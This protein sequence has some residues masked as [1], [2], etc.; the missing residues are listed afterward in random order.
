M[1]TLA[2]LLPTLSVAPSGRLSNAAVIPSICDMVPPM[3]ITSSGTSIPSWEAMALTADMHKIDCT[4]PPAVYPAWCGTAFE[5]IDYYITPLYKTP[6]STP[7]NGSST[8]LDLKHNAMMLKMNESLNTSHFDLKFGSQISEKFPPLQ[9]SMQEISLRVLTPIFADPIRA[10]AKAR[11]CFVAFSSVLLEALVGLQMLALGAICLPLVYVTLLL[12][13][14]GGLYLAYDAAMAVVGFAIIISGLDPH[15]RS[16]AS[17]RILIYMIMRIL[18]MSKMMLLA[19]LTLLSS[20]L[21]LMLLIALWLCA[22]MPSV[23]AVPRQEIPRVSALE[24]FLPG[25]SRW[26]GIPYHDFRRVWWVALCAALGNIN[27]EG[28]SLLQTARDQDLGA[29]GNPGTPGQT[30]QSDNRNQRVFGAILN[31]IEANTFLY[32]TISA[33]FANDGRGLFQYLWVYGHLAYTQ[34]E[35]TELENEWRDATIASVGIK[36]ERDAV[37]K[38]AE[39]ISVLAD[40]LGKTEAAKRTKYLAGFPNSFNVLVVA[41]RANGNPGSF[42][43]PANYPA[44]HPLAPAAHPNAGEP[45]IMAMAHG[46]YGEWARMVRSGEIKPIPKGFAGGM[47]ANDNDPSS[48]EQHTAHLARERTSDRTVCWTCGGIGHASE[49]DGVGACLTKKLGHRIPKETLSN[50]K[51]PQGY[52][53]PSSTRK[54]NP[55][56]RGS[57]YRGSTS[58][59]AHYSNSALDE[60]DTFTVEELARMLDTRSSDEEDAHLASE[61]TLDERASAAR[62][63]FLLFR[64]QQAKVQQQHAKR[65]TKAQPRPRPRTPYNKKRVNFKPRARLTQD[66]NSQETPQHSDPDAYLSHD[67]DDDEQSMRVDTSGITFDI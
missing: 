8:W 51:Y 49:I 9:F 25:V 12:L 47:R 46:F 54:Y 6:N 16:H 18:R 48:D 39:Y 4:M 19:L 55:K 24:Y 13:G 61:Q 36:Y 63:Q 50:I 38:W 52:S 37:F 53:N 60:P 29:P 7:F 11:R 14:A 30:I 41:E 33:T 57:F 15:R 17:D 3:K 23:H 40:K 66:A 42:V 26:D 34:E 21:F 59:S 10:T 62:E 28:W 58:N 65:F 32:S 45:D 22:N 35:Q 2:F 43:H 67:P 56:G 27:Q 64:M 44:H 5:K 20:R 31:Y 1:L